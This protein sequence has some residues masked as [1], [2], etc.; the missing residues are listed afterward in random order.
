V[1]ATVER[2]QHLPLPKDARKGV[3]LCFS[4]GGYRASL[5]HLGVTR[6]LNELGALSRVDTFTSVSGGSIFASVIAGYAA[7]KPEAWSQPGEPIA[8][9]DDEVV[10]QMEEL[11]RHNIRTR[12]VLSA[13]L[14]WNW[15]KRDVQ[16][17]AL[18]ERLA[19]GPTGRA[20]LSDLPDRPRFIFCSSEMQFR[21]QWTF[22]SGRR[23]FGADPCGHAEFGD[24]TIARAAA[25]SS[26]LPGAF[27]PMRI[28]DALTGGTY[29]GTDADRLAKSLALSDGGMFDNLGVEPVWQDHATVLVSDAGPS[30][31]PDPGFGKIWSQLRFAII[32]LEQAT[33]VRKRWL[34]SNFAANQL[35]GTYW[36]VAG[37]AAD[38]PSPSEPAY[39]KQFVRDFIAPIRIDLDVFSDA[40]QAVLE[41]HGYLMADT[42]LRSHAPEL[43][44][45][46]TDPQPP[47]PEWMDEGRAADA[48][49]ESGKT[50]LFA[51]GGFKR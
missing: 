49:R 44:T 4:G 26:C 1:T 5:F 42:A 6:R 48:L 41:N 20:R 28:D 15:L 51:R 13:L 19:E 33:D 23:R 32:L 11:A 47:F 27:S 8:G 39:S 18:T 29:E 30:L 9:W 34:I 31:K 10:K 21:S 46:W 2:S 3:A 24:W 43:V 7:R 17:N 16:I 50:K 40:E 22:D 25:S 12:T 14:P 38:Y 37:A 36:S 35:D 45:T